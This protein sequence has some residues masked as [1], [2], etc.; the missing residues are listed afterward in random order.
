MAIHLVCDM[1]KQ[2]KELTL[3]SLHN[4]NKRRMSPNVHVHDEPL[5]VDVPTQVTNFNLCQDCVFEVRNFITTYT[6]SEG[7]ITNESKVEPNFKVG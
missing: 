6:S 3:P 2:F 1:C 7:F 4:D 5:D